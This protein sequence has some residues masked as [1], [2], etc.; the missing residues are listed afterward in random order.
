MTQVIMST[1]GRYEVSEVEHGR[2][3]RWNPGHVVLE[4]ECGERL[5]LTR[6]ESTCPECCADHAGVIGAWLG[7][8]AGKKEDETLHPWRYWHSSEDDGMP[9]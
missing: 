5:T 1:E 4:C 6:S 9:F 7:T 8:V 2:V 3:Y